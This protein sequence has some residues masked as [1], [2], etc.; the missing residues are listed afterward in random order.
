[1]SYLT[2]IFKLWRPT[3]ARTDG[4]IFVIEQEL[5]SLGLTNVFNFS[6]SYVVKNVDSGFHANHIQTETPYVSFVQECHIITSLRT[7][8]NCELLC[9]QAVTGGR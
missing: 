3:V 6:F 7:C 2:Y 4:G 9:K 1:M 5:S 8:N